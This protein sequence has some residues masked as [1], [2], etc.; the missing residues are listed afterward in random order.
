MLVAT[1][2]AIEIQNHGQSARLALVERP[3]PKPGPGEVLIKVAAAGINRPDIL[4]KQGFYPPPEGVSDIPGL[5]VAGTLEDGAQVCALVAGG[6]YAQYCVVPAAQCLPVPKGFSMTEAAALPETFFTVWRNLFDVGKLKNGERL[7]VHGGA[8]GIG[9]TAI[10]MAKWAGAHVTITA[11]SDGKCKACLDLGADAA[12]NYKTQDFT[13]YAQNMDMVLDMIGGD[14][15]PRN[16]K[17][18]SENGR[19]VSIATQHGREAS[20]DIFR[21]MVKRLTLTGSV[22]RTRPVAEKG[23]IAQALKEHIWPVLES[24]RIRPVI[25]SVFSLE[26]AEKAHTRLESGQHFGKIVLKI[27]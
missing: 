25:D 12:I 19:H 3:V 2:K 5:E 26:D 17:C 27:C 9:T 10:Q 7:L 14:Y 18:L 22:L 6:G 13:E 21:V 20:I 1:M 24:G 23:A 8:S 4:Q 11:G 15:V 16:L